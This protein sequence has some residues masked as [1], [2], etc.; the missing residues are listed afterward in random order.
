MKTIGLIGGMSW[1]S[2][3]EYYKIVN[4]EVK[5]RLG[6][7]HSAKC[8]LYSVDFEEIERYQ[9]EDRWAEAGS[10]LGDA[11]HSLERAGAD[12][13]VICTNTMHK[14]MEYIEEKID[15]PTLHIADA[16]A[17]QINK[18]NIGTIGL[19]GT[20]Y[21]ME[22]NFYK[23]RLESNGIK[24]LTPNPLERE[25]VNKVIYEE[26]CVGNIQQSSREYY[27]QVIKNLV[28]AG[29]EGIV[30]G[31]TEIGLLVKPEDSEVP[32]FDTTVIHA[33]ESVNLALES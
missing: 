8:L 27:R 15:I 4:E 22:Q 11:A 28:D 31:C 26:L 20:K 19:L 30:L 33:V 21:T 29:A 23:S 7:L 2:T 25:M 32:L 5:H 1:E 3:A 12:F 24:V 14:V 13:I 18:S 6:G 9:A 17:N 10:L 16:T